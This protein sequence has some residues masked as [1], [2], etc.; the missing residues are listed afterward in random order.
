MAI[1][2]R[3]VLGAISSKLKTKSVS[4]N[5]VLSTSADMVFNATSDDCDGYSTFTITK[6]TITTLTPNNTSPPAITSGNV[7]LANGSGYAIQSYS[8]TSLSPS[9][10]GR[11][12]SSGWN[13]MTSSGIAYS[14]S[15]SR[16]NWPGMTLLWTNSS[17]TS[18][19]TSFTITLS[20]S[21][22]NY[23]MIHVLAIAY[24]GSDYASYTDLFGPFFK[25]SM[26]KT[27]SDNKGLCGASISVYTSSGYIRTRMVWRVS[28]TQ[29]KFSECY[30]STGS[31]GS[32]QPT[33]VIPYKVFGVK[34]SS[35]SFG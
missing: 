6:P 18:S 28:S 21:M 23:D 30:Q 16:Y 31:A 8:S 20:D 13:R 5:D 2:F 26:I 19:K 10:S 29:I 34:F 35:G 25:V 17:P 15:P 7:Y 22:D 24:T 9:S 12:F 4:G 33:G 1:T 11:S 3:S 27:E 32:K 14:S